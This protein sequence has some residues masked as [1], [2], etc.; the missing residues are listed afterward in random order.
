VW[1]KRQNRCLWNV[2]VVLFANAVNKAVVWQVAWVKSTLWTT[3]SWSFVAQKVHKNSEILGSRAPATNLAGPEPVIIMP[4]S[5][6]LPLIGAVFRRKRLPAQPNGFASISS[7]EST[8]APVLPYSLDGPLI[9][10]GSTPSWANQPWH[11]V[12]NVSVIRMIPSGY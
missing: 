7:K 4:K 10:P 2:V 3:E 5:T 11:Y 1:S 12:F 6:T 9:T 8:E